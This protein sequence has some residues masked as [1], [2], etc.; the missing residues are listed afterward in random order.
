MDETTKGNALP[1]Q[2]D[3]NKGQ[4]NWKNSGCSC[5]YGHGFG[6]VG[7]K[8]LRIIL[9]LVIVLIVFWLGIVVGSHHSF[10][11]RGFYG[12]RQIMRGYPTQRMTPLG[13]GTGTTLP[14]GMMRGQATTTPATST[15]K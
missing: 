10:S 15:Q 9:A 11:R 4:K 5:G 3:E 13:Q 12:Q 7:H 8:A 6:H 1:N 14:G 2:T